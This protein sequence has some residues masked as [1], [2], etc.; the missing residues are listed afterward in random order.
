VLG[1]F[2]Q[3]E[4]AENQFI[5]NSNSDGDKTKAQL[6]T[7]FRWLPEQESVLRH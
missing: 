3:I 6:E 7:Y 4:A 5:L 2:C 1:H